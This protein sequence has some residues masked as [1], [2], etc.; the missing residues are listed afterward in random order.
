[1]QP[2]KWV[3]H[4][5]I[6]CISTIALRSDIVSNS[7][8]ICYHSSTLRLK[9]KYR[10]VDKATFWSLNHAAYWYFCVYSIVLLY[11]LKNT[12]TEHIDQCNVCNLI[13]VSLTHNGNKINYDSDDCELEC[14]LDWSPV[15]D[16]TDPHWQNT[17]QINSYIWE[18]L[19]RTSTNTDVNTYVN[20]T[21]EDASTPFTFNWMHNQVGQPLRH[22]LHCGKS[23]CLSESWF[24]SSL[25]CSFNIAL[26]RWELVFLFWRQGNGASPVT[27]YVVQV[28]PRTP[29]PLCWEAR[30]KLLFALKPQY[31]STLIV[32]LNRAQLIS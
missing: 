10:L 9:N 13:S 21:Q 4:I 1:M 17:T 27:F 28:C 2:I 24:S 26:N 7:W 31:V 22:I 6:Y 11:N 16:R 15:H 3:C 29:E 19:H 30:S 25:F 5:S 20:I 8:H 23:H 32:C 14:T 12:F 18:Y